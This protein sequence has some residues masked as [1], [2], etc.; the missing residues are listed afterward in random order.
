MPADQLCTTAQV[1]ARLFPAGVTDNGDDTLISELIDQVSSWIEGYT[2]R[3][4]VP[5]AAATYTFDTVAWFVL[6]IPRGI[7]AVTTMGV[8][9]THQPDT[10]GTYT[11]VPAA[12]RLLRPR[13]ADS[14]EG[15]PATEVRLS[16]G[17]LAGTIGTFSTVENGCTITGDFGFASTPP[18][19]V[20]VAIDAVV[21]AYQA[22]KDGA[23]SVL[24]ADDTALPPWSRFFGRGSPQRG[25]L[26]RYRYMS[27]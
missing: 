26:D 5:E 24:G 8:A 19:V 13:A 15:W 18:D 1:K 16:R 14:P 2:G 4:L 25:T 9:M 10:G 27:V 20:A 6:R 11:T 23:S 17:L 22:R 3:K 7:R 12:D 21:A